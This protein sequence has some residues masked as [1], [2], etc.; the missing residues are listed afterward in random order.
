MKRSVIL[1]ILVPLLAACAPSPNTSGQQAQSNPVASGPKRITAAILSNPPTISADNVA[2]GSGTYQGGDS[3]EELMN[4]GLTHRDEVGRRRPQLVE[5]VPTLENGL[6]KVL[7]D[8]RMETTWTLRPNAV[9]HDGTPITTGDLLFTADLSRDKDLPVFSTREWDYVESLEASDSRTMV[10]RWKSTYINADNLLLSIRPR[11]ILERSF[12]EDKTSV[13]YHPYWNEQ[14]VGAGPFRLKEFSRDSHVTM[15]AF[16]GY[17]FGRP[18]LDE[19]T[20]KFI[21]DNNALIASILASEVQLTM[22][23]NLSLQQSMELKE[24]WKDGYIDVG[25]S[26]WIALWPQLMNPTPSVLLDVRFRRALLHALDRRQ[27]NETLLFSVAPPANILFNPSEPVFAEI[28]PFLVKYDYDPR[29]AGQL[30]EELGYTR[31]TDGMFR[32]ATGQLLTL[33]VRTSGGEDTQEA[34]IFTSSDY[35]RQAGIAAEPFIIPQAQRND[36]EYNANFPGVRLWRQ[37]NDILSVDRLHSREATLPQNRFTG[38]NRSR[39]MNPEF[40]AMIDRYM[41]TISERERVPILQQIV[42]HI[43]EN[44]TLLDLWYNAETIMVG[45]R[46][47]H[48]VNKKTSQANQ[49]WN[50]HEWDLR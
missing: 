17:V 22:G 12:T 15:S 47:Q 48:V 36:R 23:R 42:R 16:E 1:L 45:N 32:D 37:N 2:A 19:I 20:V 14:Y 10:V 35:F 5:A 29:R 31:G 6:W 43:T 3:L 49:A 18:N 25:F 24:H 11:H 41:L 21:P 39:Y 8:G 50:V 34:G 44:V 38:S 9:W 27:I 26:N 4:A 40:D 13:L 7:P 46:L 28:D 33:D 30:I